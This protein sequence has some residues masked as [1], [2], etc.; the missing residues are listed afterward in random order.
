MIL[1]DN[2]AATFYAAG[3][4]P[5]AT[6][7]FRQPTVDEQEILIHLVVA[8]IPADEVD[9][10]DRLLAEHHYLK[11]A[12]LVG[13]HLR[14]V[15]SY[16]GQWLALA[17]WSAA[18]LHI[19][20]RDQFIGWTEEQRR[21]RLPLVVNNSRLLVQPNGQCPNLISRFM[22]LML[23]RLSADWQQSWGHPVALAETFVDPHLYQ[24]T[25]YKAS[26]W[27]RLG[28]TAGWKRSAEDFYQKHERP[29]QIWVRELLPHACRKLCAQSLA[30]EWKAVEEKASPR[31]TA[32]APQMRSLVEH[33]RAE[34][35]EFRSKEALAYP[36]A[37]FLALIALAMFSGV[38][39]GPQDL[40]EYAATLSQ[41]QLRALGFRAD[42][43]TGRI[44]CPGEST[45]KRM[46]PRIDAAALE[47]ALLL[48]QEQVLGAAQDKLVI[49]DGKTL[50]HA[51]VQLVSA[52]DGSGR[53][54]G[55]VPVK[56]AS[57]EIPAARELL[58]KVPV[59]HKTALADAL[60]TQIETAQQ[61]L[62]EGGGDYALTVKE[63]QKELVQTLETLLSRSDFSPSTHDADSRPDARTQ[64]QPSGN[65]GVGMP[66][67][68]AG[69][70][71]FSRSAT[72]CAAA[73]AG[74]TQGQEEHRNGV[75]HQQPELRRTGCAGLDQTQAGLLGY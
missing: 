41:G 24:G 22:K 10:F 23:E 48:W 52:V 69:A 19:K 64:S 72:D 17:A 44:R 65:S 43:H 74:A 47:R 4:K 49:V 11:D 30:A 35:P 42:K 8:P 26:G 59:N 73:A 28:V 38:R 67:S 54:L 36:L 37:G 15:A 7:R 71:E 56:E 39:R 14:Y 3:M 57:N 32:K 20:P 75:S 50:R 18:A 70:S 53:W 13:E 34:V 63:N 46:L 21:R 6:A 40:A 45:F 29:K 61:I 12:R 66:G 16:R 9:R 68:D 5:T 60:H 25:A 62:F 51:H 31:C 33:L 1:R 27:N 55:T 2:P 58:A